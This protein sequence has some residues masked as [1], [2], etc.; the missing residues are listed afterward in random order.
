M[1]TP[2]SGPDRIPAPPRL[3][4]VTGADSGIGK[5]TAELLATEGFD[6]GITYHS[7]EAGAA[8]TAAAV[9]ERGQRCFVAR[10]DLETPRTADVVDA[11]VEQL[12]GLGVLVNNAGT[13][14]STPVLELAW[15]TWRK[16]IG[17]DLD[18]AFLCAQRAAEHM[19]AGGRGGRIVNVTSVHEKVPRAGS[20]AYCVAKAGLGMLTKCLA[21]ELSREGIT[22]N[23]VA[24]GEIATPMTGKDEREAYAERRPGNPVGRPGHVHEVASVIAFLASPRAS[25][26]TGSSFT[27]DGGLSLMAAHGHD[28]LT[29]EWRS[30]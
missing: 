4:V 29:D 26:I 28:G 19:V 20:T 3:A 16:V 8:D 11:L 10:Q 17:T 7:D 15:S 30:V 18:G 24:P 23:S 25:Y 9:R 12:G 22:V 27:V 14:H 13:G 21:L 1:S 2:D 6:V 5:A